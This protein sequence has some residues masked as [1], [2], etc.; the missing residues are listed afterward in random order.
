[1]NI[2]RQQKAPVGVA[3]SFIN[4]MMS[5]NNSLP[6]VGKGAT[7]LH[8]SDRTCYEV[9]EVSD[10]K[11]TV[12]LQRLEAK[13]NKDLPGG[14]GHQNWILEPTESYRTVIW[15]NG[16]WREKVRIV[17]FVD[18]FRN[19]IPSTSV[20][21]YL[22]EHEPELLEKVYQGHMFPQTVIEGVTKER[23]EYPKVNL[24]FGVKDYYYDWEF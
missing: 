8:H 5:N 6:E 10:D 15:R 3:G 7:E 17:E 24:L 1:M 11:K 14:Q 9:I 19:D 23:F 21:R 12:K 2:K 18:E 13:H 16:A 20:S 22:R 4:Q